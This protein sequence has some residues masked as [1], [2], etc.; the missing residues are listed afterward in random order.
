MSTDI[1]NKILIWNTDFKLLKKNGTFVYNK[2]A[3]SIYYRL[4][5]RDSSRLIYFLTGWFFDENFYMEENNWI[6][7]A[8]IVVHIVYASFPHGKC[9]TKF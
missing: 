1:K 5:D 4:L 6:S 9:L 8:T 3:G 7:C 2:F